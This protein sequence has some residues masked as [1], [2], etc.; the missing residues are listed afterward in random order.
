MT[1][2][3]IGVEIEMFQ[4]DLARRQA[5]ARLKALMGNR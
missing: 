2:L 4:A 1:W 5:H 3:P